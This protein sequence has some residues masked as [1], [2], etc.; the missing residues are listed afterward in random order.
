MSAATAASWLAFASAAALSAFCLASRAADSVFTRS[1]RARCRLAITA[2]EL[3][4]RVLA[5][6]TVAMISS[7]LLALR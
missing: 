2:W 4:L 1:V 7:G 5:A 6:V 3:A